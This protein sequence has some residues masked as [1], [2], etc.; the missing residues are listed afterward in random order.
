[1]TAQKNF[2]NRSAED[3]KTDCRTEKTENDLTKPQNRIAI[4]ENELPG[5]NAQNTRA[6]LVYVT[7]MP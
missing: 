5:Q 2:E 6:Q 4:T 3:R 1:M 7:C